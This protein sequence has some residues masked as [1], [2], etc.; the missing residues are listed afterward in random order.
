MCRKN[1]SKRGRYDNNNRVELLH[2]PPHLRPVHQHL[3]QALHDGPR[4]LHPKIDELSTQVSHMIKK[5]T[6]SKKG[7]TPQPPPSLPTPPPI[8]SSQQQHPHPKEYYQETP[9]RKR[10]GTDDGTRYSLRS[11]TRKKDDNLPMKKA[12]RKHKK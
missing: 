11:W 6:P 9:S 4:L 2:E 12:K 3:C 10:A 7:S 1:W 8:P 5:Y